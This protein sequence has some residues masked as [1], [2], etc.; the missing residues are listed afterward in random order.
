MVEP[1]KTLSDITPIPPQ[2]IPIQIPNGIPNNIPNT[3]QPTIPIPRTEIRGVW[4]TNNDLPMMENRTKLR[5]AMSQL[6][7]LNFNTVYPVIWNSGYVN[8]PTWLRRRQP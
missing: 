6:N 8:Y 4:L 3:V 2:Q 7:A 1:P 5:T